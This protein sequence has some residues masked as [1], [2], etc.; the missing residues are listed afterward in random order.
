MTFVFSRLLSSTL[1]LISIYEYVLFLSIVA[2]TTNNKGD[3]IAAFVDFTSLISDITMKTQ[4]C[5]NA[6]KFIAKPKMKLLNN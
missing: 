2:F 6:M 1:V 4:H 5:V 3:I